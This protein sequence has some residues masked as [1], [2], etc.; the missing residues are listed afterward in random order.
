MA[1]VTMPVA[2]KKSHGRVSRLREQVFGV[3]P[4]LCIERGYLMTES[5]KETES[6]PF[7]IRRARALAR[8]LKEMT[9]HIE[10]GELIVGR[11]TS[12][13]RGGL[14]I[15]EVQWE[16]YLKEMDSLSTRD[17][18]RCSPLTKEAKAK[19]KGFLP[20]WK[21]KSLYDKW[22]AVVP[23]NVLQIHAHNAYVVNAGCVSGVHLG[24]NAADYER[25]LN[26]GLNGIKREVDEELGKL[27]LAKIKD[28]EKFQFLKA[29]NI[30]L[31]AA[32][33]FAERYAGLA[34]E[35][36]EKETDTQRKTEL[37]K[38]AKICHHVPAHPARSFYEAL[39][40][41]WLTYIVLRIEGFGPG[42]SLSKGRGRRKDY[43]ARG[44]GV[45]RVTPH[46]D[47]RRRYDYE[48]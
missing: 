7:V 36:A 23:E 35:L 21:G 41:I 6:E 48:H 44:A 42:V 27:D 9:I 1:R 45:T 10:D 24:H 26:Q 29:V 28:F 4:E 32:I 31:D 47:K 46:K 12:K 37:A 39:Q 11:T 14:L 16:W 13:R 25:L 3:M 18:D 5:Y 33:G 2:G 8:I 40:S 17:W 30:T 38:I 43:Q 20:Y 22:R 34:R 19:M 15:P